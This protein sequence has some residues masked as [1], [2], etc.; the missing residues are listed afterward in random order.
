MELRV[1]VTSELARDSGREATSCRVPHL[2]G[3]GDYDDDVD[4]MLLQLRLSNYT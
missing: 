1:D 4:V 2:G 3:G